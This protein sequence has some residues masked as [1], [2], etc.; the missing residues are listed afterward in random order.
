MTSEPKSMNSL[1]EVSN[2]LLQEKKKG[3]IVTAGSNYL[4]IDAYACCVA[5]RELLV[6]KGEKAVSY[7]SAI[8]N[9]SVCNSLME[10]GQILKVLPEDFQLESAQYIIVDVSDPEYLKAAVPL[11]QISEVYDHHVG[12]E[13]YWESRIGEGAHIEFIGAAA[14]LIYREWKKA[15][16]ED[17][18]TCPTAQLLIAAILDNTLNLTSSNTT[19][20]D[21][22]A[23]HALCIK[24]NV[25]ERWSAVYFSEV[26]ASIE[27]D[28]KNA[29]FND[30][31]VIQN[32][33]ILPT[34]IAQ[35][36]IWDA[37]HV[38]MRLSEIRQWFAE[39]AEHWMINII[40]MKHYC[41]YF[42]CDDC[43]HQ[44]RLERIFNITFDMGVAKTSIPYLRKEIIKKTKS[45][46]W[47]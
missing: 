12:F 38:L 43:Y 45:K 37:E 19:Q 31:K 24:A 27:A 35:L 14:T 23:F 20:E 4:D 40:D 3:I 15:G 25:N 5:M 1:K 11:D 9:Y 6:L 18:M 8:S 32:N 46:R 17:Q 34:R 36:C 30:L 7:S 2:H 13:N 39:E 47:R 16:L 41:S 44:Q 10:D 26:Q 22:D 21:I 33:D 28:L 29:L 42:V